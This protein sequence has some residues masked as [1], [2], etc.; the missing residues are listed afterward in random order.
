MN[1]IFLNHFL[2]VVVGELQYRT[3]A[4]N[5]WQNPLSHNFTTHTKKKKR[6]TENNA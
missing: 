2:V 6:K 5:A 3:G 4:G 1:L